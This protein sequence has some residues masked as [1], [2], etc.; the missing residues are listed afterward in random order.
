[1]RQKSLRPV[2]IRIR[3]KSPEHLVRIVPTS[4][5]PMLSIPPQLY[6]GGTTHIVARLSES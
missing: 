4:H 2:N 5:H 6:N 3:I 1:M